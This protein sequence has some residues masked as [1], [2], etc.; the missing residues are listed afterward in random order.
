MGIENVIQIVKKAGNTVGNGIAAISSLSTEQVSK[1]EKKREEYLKQVPNMDDEQTQEFINKNLNVAG[2][3]VYQ[4]YLEQIKT[5]YR[6]ME[7]SSKANVK[8]TICS[9]DITKC[10]TDTQE[11]SLDK[12]VN[13]YHV[14]SSEKCNIALIYHRSIDGCKVTLGVVNTKEKAIPTATKEYYKRLTD[15]LHGNFPGTE[16]SDTPQFGIPQSLEDLTDK[17]TNHSVAVV[18]N[19]AS[20]KSEK[21]ISQSM[22]KL[23]DGIV[24]KSSEEEYTIILLAN[25]VIDQTDRINRLFELYSTLMPYSSWQTNFTQT[26][27]FGVNAGANVGI[28]AGANY[29]VQL[30]LSIGRSSGVNE[31]VG[32]IDGITQSCCNFAVQHTLDLIKEQLKRLEQSAALGMWEFAAYIIS[33][34]SVVVNNVAHMYLAL[35]QGEES[36]L[37]RSSINMWV[38]DISNSENEQVAEIIK[39]VQNL[40]HPKF[41][42][43]AG[44]DDQ[45]KECL[46]FPT[47]INPSTVLSGKE[48]AK[49][50]N[51]PRKSVAGLPVIE[52]AEFGRNISSYDNVKNG[53]ELPIGKIFHMNHEETTGVKL[54]K[55]SLASH[56][57]IT[58]STNAGKSNTVYKILDEAKRNGVKFLVVE[59]AKGEYKKVF[60][61]NE[62]VYVY[63]TNKAETPLLRLDPFSFPEKKIHVLE[64]LDRL[65]EILNVCWPMYAA[66]PAVLKN[67]VEK[68]YEDCGWDLVEST[69]EFGKNLYPNFADV[70]RNVKQII[71]SSEYDTDNKGAYKGAL[72]TRLNSLT[73]G[74]N[75]LIFQNDE[76]TAKELFDKNVIVDLSRVGSMETK[77]LI[78]GMLVL[79]LQEYR[80]SCDEMNAKLRH[81]TVLE[82]AH[83]L[84]KRTSTEQITES[85][86]LIGKSVEMI[87]NAIAEMRTY[88]EGFI[89]ADQAP[90]LLDMAVI[91][92]T[93]TKIIMRLPDLSDRELVGKA[94]NL[95]DSQIAELAKL[96]QGVAAIYQNEWIQPVLC[97]VE[98][99]EYDK[100]AYNPPTEQILKTTL[101][102]FNKSLKIAELLS[103]GTAMNR[104]LIL[105][106]I[107]PILE[108][109]KIA[110]SV[111]VAILMLLQNP[112]K[113]PRMTKL[114]PIMSALFPNVRKAIESAYSESH[115]P[116][117]W[118]VAGENELKKSLNA[119]LKDQ[120]RRDIIQA[121]VTDYAFNK[122][123]K[124]DDV[125]LWS[126]EG[127]R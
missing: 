74:I 106:E 22:E 81:L 47:L 59:P 51:F 13:V 28:N 69:N 89:I 95:N 102:D 82:E 29:G 64:H 2:I 62:G 18:S 15:A 61:N 66:M 79:K 87:S 104:E 84:L 9:V 16:I 103:N 113:E 41:G 111:H 39:H 94:A 125:E 63:G 14:L 85:S 70:A 25:P 35:T 119:E 107:T 48:L 38:S 27:G 127:L 96:P 50:L 83:N 8:S 108:E 76:I 110:S 21:F 65:I 6:P 57:F 124:I 26:Q 86:N 36:Y 56:T 20:E 109:M 117:D 19:L 49:A 97:K 4:T 10:V 93:N 55:N 122:L 121:I 114:A 58:G 52:C 37:S 88:G 1:I 90:G 32:K 53:V 54:N 116:I 43:A 80:M 72:L 99:Y 73:N 123:G 118:T 24:P 12:L 101:I 68:S 115:K 75:G 33:E 23:L 91:R 40:C 44:I 17:N 34:S 112:L 7:Y 5:L 46:T 45:F 78:M 77:S 92:N 100:K 71:N 11:N 42:L 98:E 126:K 67:A 31:Q 120:V 30:G 105:T 3:E 60:G